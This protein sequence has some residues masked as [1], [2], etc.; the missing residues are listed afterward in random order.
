MDSNLTNWTLNNINSP[1]KGSPPPMD[2]R[3]AIVQ[4]KSLPPM[5]GSALRII[6]LIS[7]PKA[8]IAKLAEIIELD[9]ILTAQI[10]R[11]SS[12]SLYGYRGKIT[13]VQDA[14]TRVLGFNFVLDLALGLAVLAPLK[15]PKD[16]VIGTRMFW[17]H[18]LA[19]TRLMKQLSEKMPAESRLNSQEVF[20]SALTHNI[21]FPLLGHQ[22]P[23]QF[24]YLKNAIQA[25]P[26][27][28]VFNLETFCFGVNHAEIGA[29]LM[30]A[31]SMPRSITNVIYHHHNPYYRGEN[32]QLNLLTFLNDTLLGQIGIGDA[33]N[34]I[35]PAEAW[36]L[37]ELNKTDCLQILD[38]LHEELEKIIEMAEILTQ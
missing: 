13:T 10:I 2:M 27:I 36:G 21:G 19:S 12:S 1:A 20:L 5:P 15:S 6:D 35:C 9:P 4:I 34:Q 7:D 17:I 33:V 31:W 23:D 8:D 29:W 14:I 30:N 32:H 22:F 11:W 3:E 38:N 37:L 25:N 26:S 16:G 28:T 24:V 18:A